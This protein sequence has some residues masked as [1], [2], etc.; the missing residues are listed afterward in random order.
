MNLAILLWPKNLEYVLSVFPSVLV[1]L[2][3][4]NNGVA[5]NI[6]LHSCL[7]VVTSRCMASSSMKPLVIL[8]ALSCINQYGG[9]SLSWQQVLVLIC[10]LPLCLLPL[11][12]RWAYQLRNL[13]AW[14]RS[15]K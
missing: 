8:G 10:F 2:C 15:L 9:V 6:G 12:I 3:G 14:A 7:L 1:R 13:Y 11:S 5:P 4:V